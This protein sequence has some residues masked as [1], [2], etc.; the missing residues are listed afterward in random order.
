[1]GEL[2]ERPGEH[3]PDKEEDQLAERAVVGGEIATV[4][5]R[6]AK[7]QPGGHPDDDLDRRARPGPSRLDPEAHGRLV[8]GGLGERA[9]QLTEPGRLVLG[10]EHEGCDAMHEADLLVLLGTDFP[11]DVFLPQ[12]HTVQVDRDPAH[13][14]RRTLLDLA[15][16][17]DVAATLRG[18]QSLLDHKRDRSFLDRMLRRHAESLERVV[19][20]YTRDVEHH[21]PIHPEY[22]AAVLDDVAADD[23]IFTVDTGMGNVWA[24]RYLT[25]NCRRRVIGS[26]VHGSMANALP[27]AIG[28]QLGA[29]GRQVISVSG[30]GG[31]G[32]LLGELLTVRQLDLPVK[33]VVF[34]NSSLGMVKLEMLVDGIPELGTDNGSFDYAGIARAVGIDSVRVEDPSA[35]REALAHYLGLPGPALVELVTDPNALSIP[36]HVSGA[37]VRGFA[38]AA[39][40][41][42]LAGGVGKMID[43]ARSNLRNIPRP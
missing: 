19:H 31:L 37:Q 6:E 4:E 35:V 16:H 14:G 41:T 8:P 23:A 22:A 39:G 10:C 18:V 36:P 26:F 17:G 25:P 11:Y 3:R 12:A 28:A 15:V 21:I 32:M 29:P 7:D 43:M 34:N 24:A 42:V 5:D 13:L 30:D 1:V 33:I 27:R 9:E 20:A 2:D 40:R 38:L